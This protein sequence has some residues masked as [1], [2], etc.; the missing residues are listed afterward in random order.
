MLSANSIANDARPSLLALLANGR[1]QH[2]A[3]TMLHGQALDLSGG[4]RCMLFE[5]NPTTGALQVTSAR[6]FTQVP[7]DPW[8]PAFHDAAVVSQAFGTESVVPVDALRSEMPQLFARLGSDA[9]L[10]VPLVNDGRRV[11][12]LTIGLAASSAADAVDAIES[13]DLMAGLLVALELA[14]LRQH[15]DL[16]VEVRR[17]VEAFS[18]HL[19]LELELSP[20]LATL[21]VE[22]AHLFG[23]HRA[24]V[25]LHDRENR[26][27]RAL[28]SS[29]PAHTAE[30]SP[31][32]VDDPTSPA[33]G[34]LRR[35]RSGLVSDGHAATSTM[36]V[37]LRGSRRALGAVVFEG[38][39]VE[40]GEDLALLNRADELGRQLSGTIQTIQL[41][42]SMSSSRSEM[43]GLPV[44]E[45]RTQEELRD[46]VVQSEKLAALADFVAG[47]A[48]E[49]N[50]PLQ[51]VIG[52]LELLTTTGA[53]PDA[54]RHEMRTIRR[55]AN[56]AARIVR[57]LLAFAGSGRLQRRRTGLN[58]ILQRVLALRQ[59]ACRARRIDLVRQYDQQLPRVL[60]DPLLL[61]QVFLNLVM[62][63][64]QAVAA[65]GRPGRIEV[66]SG[67][68][69]NPDWVM[70][71]IRDTGAGI[72]DDTLSRLFEPFYTTR[73]VG[74]G[75][76][77]G[78][79]LAYGI[80][81]EH[82]GRITAGNHPEG[83]AVFTVELPIA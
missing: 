13:S 51:S 22:S 72:V 30:L 39:R 54:I 34:A 9:A 37:P 20:A 83:G 33:A 76:G 57:T 62:N 48:H 55:D 11:G 7:T 44:V 66:T 6:G 14:R 60:V 68:G 27:V 18:E 10:L 24:T 59:A 41:L 5:H 49:L 80:V 69:R 74:Q 4:D 56:R 65:G 36:A 17:I 67:E 63:A 40:P 8:S 28:A 29:D 75:A 2:S 79:T 78:L 77:L 25:W 58:G 12:L 32:R 3:L 19:S 43:K 16:E 70:A 71:S 82:G 35:Q 52:H 1:Q 64:E 50:N 73:D 61:H 38:V 47:I 15:E 31:V 26:S 21:C 53:V 45:R 46:Q 81:Q 23:A 42:A